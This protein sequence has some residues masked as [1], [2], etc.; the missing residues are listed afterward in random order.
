[1]QTENNIDSTVKK[2][3]FYSSILLVVVTLITWAIAMTALPNSGKYCIKDCV[4]YPYLDTLAEYPRDY[5]WM[6]I[7]P[8][9]VLI[10]MIFVVTLHSSV[11]LR[12]KIF[13]R[14]GLA[15]A[16]VASTILIVCYYIQFNVVPSSLLNQETEGIAL[17]TQYNPHGVFIA[18]EELGY[19]LMACSFL[20]LG[21]ACEGSN[22]L[23]RFI[24]WIYFGAFGFMFIA[25][26]L[27]MLKFGVD[28]EDLFELIVISIDWL[29]LIINGILT[30]I[31]FK[32]AMKQS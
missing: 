7:A 32:R 14:I 12:N 23:E 27:V 5:L 6:F 4:D 25:Y 21:L 8:L 17:L 15:V 18:M 26:A 2:T 11:P 10:Y 9:Q 24:Q 28:R 1:M 13:S 31:V 22:R 16:L 20:F 29:V 3:G 30:A 19:I